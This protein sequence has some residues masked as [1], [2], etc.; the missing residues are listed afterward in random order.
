MSWSRGDPRDP[1]PGCADRSE[2]A[3]LE[4]EPT[5]KGP[6][7]AHVERDGVKVYYEAR[8]DGPPVLLSHGYSATTEMWQGQVEALAPRYR[9][10]VWD[11][12]G[13]GQT[14][15]PDDPAAYSEE[16]TVGDMAAV[17]GVCDPDR[18]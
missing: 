2:R 13:H 5:G 3:M 15:S 11:M 7:M 1:R 9:V 14:D 10:I 17:P 16:S 18:A 12:R 4:K 8:G 6:T